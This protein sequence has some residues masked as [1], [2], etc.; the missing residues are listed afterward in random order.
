MA[1]S[2]SEARISLAAVSSILV[3]P[4]GIGRCGKLASV[5]IGPFRTNHNAWITGAPTAGTLVTF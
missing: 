2:K 4:V 3:W 1:Q 5:C